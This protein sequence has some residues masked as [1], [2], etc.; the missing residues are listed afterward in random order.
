MEFE[1]HF[2]KY[3]PSDLTI[4]SQVPVSILKT[5]NIFIR[6]FLSLVF[7]LIQTREAESP[8][9]KRGAREVVKRERVREKD[10]NFKKIEKLER[11][12]KR[13]EEE[14]VKNN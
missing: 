8:R 13:D 14:R 3:H 9:E 12:S 6:S 1:R 4:R 5:N 10:K 2:S 7:D 11:E